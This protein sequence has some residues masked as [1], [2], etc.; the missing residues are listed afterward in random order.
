MKSKSCVDYGQLALCH[1]QT[2]AELVPMIDKKNF[3]YS[4]INCDG[5]FP[6]FSYD[7]YF[8]NVLMVKELPPQKVV[9][10]KGD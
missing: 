2:Q 5:L 6:Q 4:S 3:N 10:L 7:S 9:E 1:L 8:C